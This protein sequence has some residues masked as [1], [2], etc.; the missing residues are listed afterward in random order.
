MGQKS[1]TASKSH[2]TRRFLKSNAAYKDGLKPKTAAKKHGDSKQ[3]D[4][5]NIQQK[6]LIQ[7]RGATKALKA[8][9]RYFRIDVAKLFPNFWGSTV[10]SFHNFD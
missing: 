10:Q 9:V 3:S 6:M 8:V 5:A 7:K 2:K 4:L 1:W